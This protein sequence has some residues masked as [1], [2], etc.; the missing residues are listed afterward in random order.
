MPEKTGEFQSAHCFETKIDSYELYAD[1]EFLVD[2]RRTG[3]RS[4]TGWP[5][6][7]RK[8]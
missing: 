8:M 6:V 2:V 1:M 4:T 3:P 5:P 7:P